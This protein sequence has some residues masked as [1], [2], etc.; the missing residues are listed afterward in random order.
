MKQTLTIIG[1][2]VEDLGRSLKFY[3]DGLGWTPVFET[4]GIAF[5]QM[6]G[7]IFSVVQ[8]K[9]LED[10]FEGT[11]QMGGKSVTLA[12]NVARRE[13]VDAVLAEISKITGKPALQGP[14]E[15]TWGGYSGYFEDPD[16][17]LWE[18]A[19]NPHLSLSDE[20]FASMS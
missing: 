20:G 19:W 7:V 5:F 16:G 15:R 11:I 17:H 12:H 3:K 10:D 14:V 9:I 1:L 13:D 2:A 8:K 18:V 4:P 6:N